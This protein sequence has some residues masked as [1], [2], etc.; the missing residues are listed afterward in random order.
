MST[1]VSIGLQTENSS[2]FITFK[3]LRIDYVEFQEF[4]IMIMFTAMQR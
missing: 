3:A 2:H 1:R 4:R